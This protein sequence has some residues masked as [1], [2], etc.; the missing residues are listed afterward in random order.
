MSQVARRSDPAL[1]KVEDRAFTATTD[2]AREFALLYEALFGRLVRFAEVDGLDYQDALDVVQTTMQE[3]WPRWPDVRVNRPGPAYFF[4]AVSNQVALFKRYASTHGTVLGTREVMR[5]PDDPRRAPDAVLEREEFLG[6]ASQIIGGL[7]ERCRQAFL[8][9]REAE[10]SYAAA[11][12]VMGITRDAVKKN[13]ARA[14]AT[15][16]PALE[17]AGYGAGS[18]TR[19]L[20]VTNRPLLETSTE[21]TP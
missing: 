16:G 6:V 8:L 21:D 9:V 7:P 4:K 19:A 20:P 14:L 15:L 10:L 1:V 18:L 13:L 5:H 12:D 3:I 2:S 11:A 17:Q